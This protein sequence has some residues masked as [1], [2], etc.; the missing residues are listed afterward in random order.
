M[1]IFPKQINLSN[2]KDSLIIK[3]ND[4]SVQTLSLLKLRKL[5]PCAFCLA[6]KEKQSSS[7]IPI[8]LKNQIEISSINQVGIMRLL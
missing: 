5:C 1:S 2:K 6:D 3:W 4:N 7:Y 8:F